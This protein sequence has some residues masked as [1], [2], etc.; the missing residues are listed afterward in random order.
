MAKKIIYTVGGIVQAGG[1]LYISRNADDELLSLCRDGT[2]AYVLTSRQMGK[3]SLMVRTAEQLAKEKIQSVIIDLEEL[4][5]Q[6]TAEAWYLGMLTNI[7]ARLRLKTNVV[8]WWR[9]YAH[10]SVNQR[11]A[12]FFQEIL[13]TEVSAPVVIFIDEIDTTIRLP[14]A[15][16]F[17]AT[18]R[19]FYN[20]R[21]LVPEF[22]RLSFVLIGTATPS[23]LIS[24]P[25]RT[26]FNIGQRVDLTDFT[27][28][29][30]LPLADGFGLP[31][32]MAKQTLNWILEWTGGHPYLTQKLCVAIAERDQFNVTKTDVKQAVERNFFGKMSEQDSNLQYV[33]DMLTKR[34]PDRL[35]VLTTYR[36][37]LLNSRGIHDE[38]Q[39][40][41]KSHLKLSGVMRREN[42]RLFVRN[43]IYKNVFNNKWVKEHWPAR[44]W[45]SVPKN[46]K[47]AA[48]SAL[49]L[50][51]ALVVSLLMM[52]E[53]Q[54][55]R[56]TENESAA[57]QLELKALQAD[58]ARRA[59]EEGT[60]IVGNLHL[61]EI[62]RNLAL[63]APR[64]LE[65]G[66]NRYDL[67]AL[68]ARQAYR[69]NQDLLKQNI[70]T[71]F[72]DQ[73][74]DALHK[75]LYNVFYFNTIVGELDK[76]IT[77]A[78][79][80]KDG[81][82][83]A[84]SDADGSVK[85]RNLRQR[86]AIPKFL[87]G[88]AQQTMAMVFI[89]K[90]QVLAICYAD[91]RVIYW[92]WQKDANAREV[93]RFKLN[94]ITAAAFSSDGMLI[95][96]GS[97]KGTVLLYDLRQHKPAERT[98]QYKGKVRSLV[99]GSG[100]KILI[101]GTEEG[102]IRVWEIYQG[103]FEQK[104]IYDHNKG[105]GAL[106]LSSDSG[107]LASGGLNGEVW[108]WDLK[109]H[110]NR[111]VYKFTHNINA[112]TAVAF[113]LDASKI[114]SGGSDGKIRVYDQHND[115]AS[116][117][118][119]SGH[120][121]SVKA[122]SVSPE[123]DF[124]VSGSGDKTVHWWYLSKSIPNPLILSQRNNDS[125][126]SAIRAVA[127]HPDGEMIASGGE[128]EKVRLWQLHGEATESKV[129]DNGHKDIVR[130]VAFSPDGNFLAS[131]SKDKAV[132]LWSLKKLSDKPEIGKGHDDEICSVA[133]GPDGKILASGSA[134]KTV[135]LW[136]LDAANQTSK[137]D[138][139]QKD[140][141]N[142]E[143]E[144]SCVVF[145]PKNSVLAS[146]GKN[147]KVRLWDWRNPKHPIVDKIELKSDVNAIAISPDGSML[148]SGCA[149]GTVQLH[150]IPPAVKKSNL[151]KVLLD[152]GS[153]VYSVGF[154]PQTSLVAAGIA[155]GTIKIW[156]LR[157]LD[158]DPII[159]RGHDNWV[160]SIAFDA[161]GTHIIS[162][163]ADK[164]IRVWIASIDLLA[165]MVCAKVW[166]NL[167]VEEWR[168]FVG[169]DIPYQK[170]CLD[171]P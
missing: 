97:D 71:N 23:D 64:Q 166:R 159:L 153:A 16:D 117:D 57:R 111:P 122:L 78:V 130:A 77:A 52:N 157:Q 167:T 105:V 53:I 124:L 147:G 154:S 15:D 118:V 46:V 80:S 70:Q 28:E 152:H 93:Y 155:D 146:S 66:H 107:L 88:N 119:L 18:V 67:A 132:R 125:K 44:W 54:K 62:T 145:S 101:A 9:S 29:E 103:N 8:N 169:A 49:V 79:F 43:P 144:V 151:L 68:L 133:F 90:D 31:A 137:N 149:N 73:I 14:F 94:K 127:I 115:D 140:V 135:R 10:L 42:G 55:R 99:F 165:S 36:E 5:T 20:A 58:S 160:Y 109:N 163:S 21:A 83:L 131:G 3:S 50:L 2:F 13:L 56:Q 92:D 51:I 120:E 89:P 86:G 19:Y 162:G 136:E 85:I 65:L 91:G 104:H 102:A 141:F 30:A 33:H 59:A 48:G 4:G 76:E 38:E 121:S 108:L 39:S 41:I 95:A 123:G 161:D 128:D 171:L 138:L 114:F 6:I 26:P 27:F 32:D 84:W 170:V 142:H 40:P 34:A 158:A 74:Y 129:L 100:G 81:R 17:Y 61:K 69:I 47:I 143:D 7:F 75:A 1:G 126:L 11:M 134:D 113:S 22:H 98:L 12:Q 139:K 168:E 106:A 116:P 112:I 164:T 37:I 72:Q 148:V 110:S 45:E 82:Y 63:Q 96:C 60:K 24:D 150:N 87:P 156:N 35:A 25:K